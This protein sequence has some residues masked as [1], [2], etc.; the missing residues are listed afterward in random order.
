MS[1]ISPPTRATERSRII[2]SERFR[3]QIS[4]LL[5][6]FV[7]KF[8]HGEY[9]KSGVLPNTKEALI[10]SDFVIPAEDGIRIFQEPGPLCPRGHSPR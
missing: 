4:E 8:A 3:V 9:R 2:G 10:N 6:R 5:G 1:M 7:E